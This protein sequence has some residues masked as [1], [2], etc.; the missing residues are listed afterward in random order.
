MLYKLLQQN[1]GGLTMKTIN[2]VDQKTTCKRL[3]QLTKRQL[4]QR[5]EVGQMI[6]K[7]TKATLHKD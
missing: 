5:A 2:T 3:T 1:C 6:A 4:V 7:M